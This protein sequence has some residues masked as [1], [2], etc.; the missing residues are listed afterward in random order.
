MI[1]DLREALRPLLPLRIEWLE[2]QDPVLTV[3][4]DDWSLAL[5]CPWRLQRAG[6][7]VT[8]WD[9]EGVEDASWDLVGHQI[10]RVER[11]K[12]GEDEYPAFELSDGL[13]LEV[14]AD[15]DVDPWVLRLPTQTIV[16]RRTAGGHVP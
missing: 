1:D 13:R 6:T 11:R 15:S 14:I 8:A 9:L 12:A 3:G 4:G 2:Y 16:G 5:V 10:N 7:T